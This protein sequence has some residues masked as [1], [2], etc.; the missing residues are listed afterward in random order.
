MGCEELDGMTSRGSTTMIRAI[1]IYSRRSI[2]PRS[3]TGLIIV[4]AWLL[5]LFSPSPL[6]R[7][8]DHILF[9]LVL[10]KTNTTDT[11][12]MRLRVT[13]VSKLA[14]VFQGWAR[15]FETDKHNHYSNK[16]KNTHW[17]SHGRVPG[18]KKWTHDVSFSLL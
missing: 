7:L 1:D 10:K 5:C 9:T 14:R 6:H 15:V 8:C 18:N 4:S 13:V 12:V 17:S 11:T 16:Y 2:Y 3:P